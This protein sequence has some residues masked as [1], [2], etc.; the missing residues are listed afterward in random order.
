MKNKILGFSLITAG[1]ILIY[2][3]ATFAPV[4]N[5]I[6]ARDFFSGFA[7]G[8]GLIFFAALVVLLIKKAREKS[9]AA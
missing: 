8:V 3:F 2:V 5:N 6:N 7:L 1:C 4:T 9:A